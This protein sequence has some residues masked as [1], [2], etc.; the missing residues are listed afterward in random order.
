MEKIHNIENNPLQGHLYL[1]TGIYRFVFDN[2]HSF[3][4]GKHIYYAFLHLDSS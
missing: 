2:S 4:R 1:K 3:M